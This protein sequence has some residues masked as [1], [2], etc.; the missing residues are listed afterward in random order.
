MYTPGE[1]GVP[2]GRG[3]TGGGREVDR[4]EWRGAGCICA[5]SGSE[6]VTEG[7]RELDDREID[8]T[9]SSRGDVIDGSRDMEGGASVSVSE[10]RSENEPG[11]RKAGRRGKPGVAAP[12]R[13][14]PE[15]SVGL[16][17]CRGGLRTV[18][19][20]EADAGIW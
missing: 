3:T 6:N 19:V 18:E 8:V 7:V 13:A 17:G 5:T 15:T 12:P 10:V 16:R 1:T 4:E 14:G 2:P 9:D 11:T 20:V